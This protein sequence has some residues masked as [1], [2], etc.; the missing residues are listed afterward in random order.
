[1]RLRVVDAALWVGVDV[2]GGRR[3]SH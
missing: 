1:V 3:V 2:D